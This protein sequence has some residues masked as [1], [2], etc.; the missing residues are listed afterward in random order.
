VQKFTTASSQIV[1]TPQQ[2][3]PKSDY[4]V[5]SYEAFRRHPQEFVSAVKP[6]IM[7]A[8]EFHR[9][10]NPRSQTN[11]AIQSVRG[12]IPKFVGMTAS[13]AQNDPSDVAPLLSLARGEPISQLGFKRKHV[14]RQDA[15]VRGI[16]GGRVTKPVLKDED[17]LSNFVGQSI[18]YVEDLDASE[19]PVKDASTVE[20]PMSSQQLEAY[21]MTLSGLD[22]KLRD[23]MMFGGFLTGKERKNLLTRIMLARKASNSLH[24]V[25]NMSVE[26]SAE[27]T[28]KV[29]QLL[30]DVQEHLKA[31]PDGQVIV[32][33]NFVKG[34]VDVVSAGLKK[35]G[36]PF[37]V[38][39][40]RGVPGMTEQARQQAVTDY[41]QTKNRVI[42]ITGAGAEGLS[43]GDTTMV[44]MLDGSYNPERNFQAE[45]RGIRAGGLSHRPQDQ[46]R[47]EVKR[48]VS[49]VPRGFWQAITFRPKQSSV[50]QFVYG[51]AERKNEANRTLRDVLRGQSDSEAKR[52]D[53]G[54]VYRFFHGG[55]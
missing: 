27:K 31:T 37:G 5:V 11:Q 40:G 23:K 43:L 9:A 24:T 44:A 1:T 36:I 7:I 28:P 16:F 33:T 17:V 49:T 29:K 48:Y 55:Y 50:D 30:T 25:T 54:P 51:T 8:D 2:V 47:V 45:A 10:S 14:T 12:E 6:D 32:Y 22:P 13:I 35:A 3:N 39:A 52:R 53:G 41:Q 42:V 18:H 19:K 4:V 21:K 38:F 26:D 34:G 46:R 15:G 20:V